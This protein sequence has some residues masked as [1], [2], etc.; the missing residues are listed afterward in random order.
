MGES[1]D[2]FS[3]QLPG[4]NAAEFQCTAAR[5]VESGRAHPDYSLVLLGLKIRVRTDGLGSNDKRYSAGE[6]L[7]K[8]KTLNLG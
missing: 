4:E 3:I 1:A 8:V 2:T 6:D 5:P 7:T